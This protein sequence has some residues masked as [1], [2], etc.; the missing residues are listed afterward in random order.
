MARFLIADIEEA[1]RSV[2]LKLVVN[3]KQKNLSKYVA[4]DANYNPVFGGDTLAAIA[5]ALSAYRVTLAAAATTVTEEVV[6][7]VEEATV[8]EE[9][10]EIVATIE[11]A[12]VIE[13]VEK[14]EQPA[15]DVE[16]V[17]ITEEWS[18]EG[19]DT[20]GFYWRSGLPLSQAAY[21]FT[22]EICNYQSCD[23]LEGVHAGSCCDL[24]P[25]NDVA[26][27]TYWLSWWGNFDYAV[28]QL[29]G[30]TAAA[31]HIVVTDPPER[32]TPDQQ[33][34]MEMLEALYHPVKPSE[35]ADEFISPVMIGIYFI[36]A[37]ALMLE[38]LVWLVRQVIEEKLV[39]RVYDFIKG[40]YRRH[41]LRLKQESLSRYALV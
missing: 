2:N 29:K 14:I 27:E 39:Q 19:V 30:A 6:A 28:R 17:A 3:K 11:E 20:S 41:V 5:D 9:V 21:P 26:N 4:T 40:H 24:H 33:C 36:A 34:E 16:V 7:T 1:L 15:V 25:S 12:T 37:I 22:C 35:P 10:E 18:F 13:E 31:A 8:I 23:V 38:G 32:V